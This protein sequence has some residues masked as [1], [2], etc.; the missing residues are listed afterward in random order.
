MIQLPSTRAML[1]LTL[2]TLIAVPWVA[3]AA[4]GS[5]ESAA[6]AAGIAFTHGHFNG[7]ADDADRNAHGAAF[8][9]GQ[10]RRTIQV[11]ASPRDAPHT[12]SPADRVDSF[13]SERSQGVLTS[14]VQPAAGDNGMPG[15][16][17]DVVALTP[18]VPEP[19]T[20]ALMLGG[21]AAIGFVIRRRRND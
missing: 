16:T 13:W 18:A 8:D 4:D 17:I 14:D 12:A 3:S 9:A 7:W 11:V 6:H 15:G 20:Y 19:G 2:V 1:R 21:L 5:F 10:T